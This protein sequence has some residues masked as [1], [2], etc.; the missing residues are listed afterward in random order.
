[1]TVPSREGLLPACEAEPRV[2]SSGQN[3]EILAAQRAGP[4]WGRLGPSWGHLGAPKRPQDGACPLSPFPLN[5]YFS[6]FF[7]TW[8]ASW[9]ISFQVRNRTTARRRFSKGRFRLDET[10][11]FFEGACFVE[12][13]CSKVS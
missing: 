2:V 13:K 9:A 1:M 10:T 4:S 6:L 7:Y 5:L 3:R 11:T 8:T 12:A